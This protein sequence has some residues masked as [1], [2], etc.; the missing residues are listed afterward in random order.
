MKM[1]RILKKI[2]FSKVL[3]PAILLSVM[4]LAACSPAAPVSQVPGAEPTLNRTPVSSLPIITPIHAPGCT[5]RSAPAKA[6]STVQSLLPAVT[7]EDWVRGPSDAFVTLIEYC[8]FQSAG[9]AQIVPVLEK[10]QAKYPQDVRIAYRHFPLSN[11]DKAALATQAAEAA[12]LQGKFWD[13][14]DLLFTQQ[15]DWVGLS[16]DQFK[17]WINQRASDL[18]LDVEKFKTDMNSEKMAVFA[19]DTFD[20]NAAIGMPGVPFLVANG[21]PYNAPVDFG[22]LDTMTALL[23][24]EKRQFPDCPPMT[25][26]PKKQ[27]LAVLHTG[28]GDITLELFADKA[29]LAVNS[30]IF[31]ARNHWFDGVTF[32]RVIPGFVA[33]AGDPTGTGI[34]GPGYAFDNEI[35]SDLTFDGPGVLGMANA[36]PGSNGSQFFITYTAVPRLNGGY[37]I[38]GKLIAGMNVLQMLTSRD[39]ST[40]MDLPPGDKIL[41]VEIVEK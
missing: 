5:V 14:H 20:R 16:A 17:D 10:L 39:P 40:A 2:K 7:K 37:T 29:P 27:Y 33:Q 3:L 21:L 6:N 32:H 41:S 25:I 19:R 35:S 28:K 38:F 36:G 31:L 8:D 15:K 30:F 1:F 11:D 22:N 26:D 9:C 18:H 4:L 24:L 23:L 13:M 12:G 34:G